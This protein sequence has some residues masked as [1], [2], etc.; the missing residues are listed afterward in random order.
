[1]MRFIGLMVWAAA[2]FAATADFA[3]KGAL[4]AGQTLELKGVNGSI[5]VVESNASE[6]S[7]HAVRSGRKSDP[8]AV[9]VDV[10]P[11]VGGVTI[12]AVYP[13]RDAAK[14]NEC[15]PGDG[16]RMNVQNNDVNVDF[17]VQLPRGLHLVAKTVNGGV[18]VKNISGDV[19]AHTVNGKI[20]VDAKGNVE[21]HTVNGS[22]QASMGV[23]SWTGTREFHT[24]NGGITLDL[25]AG[26]SAEVNA[27]VTNGE[28][29]SDFPLMVKGKIDRRQLHA[30][31]GNGGRELKLHTVNGSI[32]IR[33]AS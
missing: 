20:A 1:M 4:A 11:H 6:I 32:R 12:C 5:R 19:K 30:T 22:I 7:L 25:P 15:K 26:A 33:R 27:K 2:S 28:I 31:I 9:R 21:A 23:T 14:P 13:S 16:G 18:D 10:V 3:W 17:D 29:S 8:N 24:V